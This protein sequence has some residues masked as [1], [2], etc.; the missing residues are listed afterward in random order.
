MQQNNISYAYP[1]LG[2]GAD[3][4]GDFKISAEMPFDKLIVLTTNII[5]FLI[6]YIDSNEENEEFIIEGMS[7]L[8][9]GLK[10]GK[11]DSHYDKFSKKGLKSKFQSFLFILKYLYKVL[12]LLYLNIHI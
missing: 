3:V 10:I 12:Y 9:F 4:A 7:L 5:D 2:N 1:V 6:E 8:F 11:E